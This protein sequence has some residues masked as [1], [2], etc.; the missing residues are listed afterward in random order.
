MG[1]SIELNLKIDLKMKT[2]VIRNGFYN[3]LYYEYNNLNEVGE[4]VQEYINEYIKGE[5]IN[6]QKN[7]RN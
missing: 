7:Q 1:E 2:L 6:E 3:I 4:I 5:T